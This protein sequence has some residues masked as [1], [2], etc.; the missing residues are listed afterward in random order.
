MMNEAKPPDGPD[1]ENHPTYYDVA[2]GFERP[3]P[4][5]GESIM[6]RKLDAV[7]GE[8]DTAEEE[9]SNTSAQFTGDAD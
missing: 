5:F 8:N 7:I 6:D 3:T 9:Q 4:R 2:L 1:T